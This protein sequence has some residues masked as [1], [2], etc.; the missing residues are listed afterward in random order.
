MRNKKR[1][2]HFHV[3]FDTK[4]ERG[5]LRNACVEQSLKKARVHEYVGSPN[6]FFRNKAVLSKVIEPPR[7]SL[8]LSKASFHNIFDPEIWLTKKKT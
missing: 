6:S 8:A 5:S 7:S 4:N 3:H 1:C 2:K